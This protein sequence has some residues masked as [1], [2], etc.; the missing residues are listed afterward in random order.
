MHKS[1]K[2]GQTLD[3]GGQYVPFG[4]LG[5]LYFTNFHAYGHIWRRFDGCGYGPVRGW[6]DE[7]GVFIGD[8]YDYVYAQV[9]QIG[10]NHSY[11]ASL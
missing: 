11:Q 9:G 8:R 6:G 10:S 5:V 7:G 2:V 1:V 4:E 3:M